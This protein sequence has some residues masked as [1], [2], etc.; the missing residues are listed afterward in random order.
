MQILPAID[1]DSSAMRFADILVFRSSAVAAETAN[2]PPDPIAATPSSGSI[3]SPL[4]NDVMALL[5][6][7]PPK[8]AL[9]MRSVWLPP[10]KTMLP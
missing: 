6:W 9:S 10:P 2:G 1:I 3:T 4:P 5:N 7:L 8:A